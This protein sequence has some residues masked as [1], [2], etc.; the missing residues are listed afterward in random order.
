MSQI[1]VYLLTL[2]AF[3]AIYANIICSIF[4]IGL[5]QFF[6]KKKIY[7]NMLKRK[8]FWILYV[9]GITY[10]IIG[11]PNI[12]GLEFYFVTPILTYTSGWIICEVSREKEK[13][14]KNCIYVMV[15]SNATHALLNYIVN[16]GKPRWL[17]V[18][19]FSGNLRAATGSGVI[20]TLVFS[21]LAYIIFIEKRKIIKLLGIGCFIIS[22]LYSFL[23]GTRTQFGILMIV[24]TIISIFYFRE[25]SG[26]KWSIKL[27]LI[28]SILVSVVYLFYSKNFFGIQ[29]MIDNSNLMARFVDSSDLKDADG[30]RL[31]SITR[32]LLFVIEHPFGGGAELDYFHNMWLDIGRV[33]GILPII[34]MFVYSII[35]FHHIYIIFKSS[36]FSI[37]IRYILLSVYLGININLFFEPILEGLM[38]YFLSYILLNG[39]V[40]CMYYSKNM[41][42]TSYILDDII[43]EKKKKNIRVYK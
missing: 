8:P 30:Y 42:K 22:V 1:I 6:K 41:L 26:W 20:N 12:Q 43:K 27:F 17:L 34:L 10:W 5:F 4:I 31:N 3:N 28:S 7:L 19:F 14:V 33:A 21:L 24:F 40:D 23:L 29:T 32:G 35:T 36:F 11:V 18:D 2:G 9:F 16:L 13:L 37:N 15:L 38:G 25:K 39:L